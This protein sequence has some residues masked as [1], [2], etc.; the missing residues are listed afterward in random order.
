[1]TADFITRLAD[2]GYTKKDSAIILGD[3]LDI[4]YE[5][6]R[7]GE[8]VRITGF[9]SFSTIDTMPK[10]IRN[11]QTGELETVA[12]HKKVKFKPGLSLKR[13]AEGFHD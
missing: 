8:E 12:S 1:M 11:I 10:E 7:T 9:G 3:V 2:K 4:I 13:A 5:A 6:I